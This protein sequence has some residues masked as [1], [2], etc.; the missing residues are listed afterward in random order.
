MNKLSDKL[1]NKPTTFDLDWLTYYQLSKGDY[2]NLVEVL[3]VW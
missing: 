3:L 1:D 2:L